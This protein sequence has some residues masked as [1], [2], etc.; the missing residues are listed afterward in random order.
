MLLAHGVA[1]RED[2]PLP[3]GLALAGAAAA[4]FVSFVAVAVLW[5]EPRLTGAA[6][7]RTVPRWLSALVDSP[8]SRGLQRT[9]GVVLTLFTLMAALFG[10]DDDLNPTA[11]IVFVVFWV[12]LPVASMLLGPVGRR[13]SPIRGLHSLMARTSN[14]DPDEGL[15]PLPPWLGYLPAALGLLAFTYLELAAPNRDSARLL[16]V[17]A[18]VYVL[19]HA[20]LAL[21]FGRR[22]F[23]LGESF[24]VLSALVGRVS[25]LGR[26]APRDDQERGDLVVR[27]PWDGLV[28]VPTAPW[29]VLLVSVMLGSTLWD[30]A[31]GTSWVQDRLQAQSV[32]GPDTA[33][34]LGLLAMVAL[35]AGLFAL[36]TS[37]V[38]AEGIPSRRLP[39]LLAGSLVPIVAGYLVAHYFSLL[40]F[41]SQQAVLLSTD[42]LGTGADWFGVTNRAVNF[43]LVSPSTIARVQV[44]AVVIG[45]VL[46]VIVAHDRAVGT[47]RRRKIVGQLPLLVLMIA[48]TVGGI[49]LLFAR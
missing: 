16:G 15:R 1:S 20:C 41:G 31:S 48:L 30:S 24:E 5:R 42:P 4:V 44:L 45:H 12:G 35:V 36:G 33:S 29:L 18:V 46:A 28:S 22:W 8:V 37:L 3:F 14:V 39:R 49:A 26:R 7:G 10:P 6:A 17:L 43:S 40:V 27:N 19:L 32:L 47:Y 34:T 13:L 9:V 21:V 11:N 23:A 38:P 25:P 2:L